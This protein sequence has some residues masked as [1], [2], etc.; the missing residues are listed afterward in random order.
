MFSYGFKHAL[1][2]RGLESSGGSTS[3]V[4]G[5]HFPFEYSAHLVRGVLCIGNI[6]ADAVHVALEYSPRKHIGRE[7]AVA[8]FRAAERHR[9][10]YAEGHSIHYPTRKSF[11]PPRVLGHLFEVPCWK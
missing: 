3:E 10:V 1:Q 8:A 6:A 11:H 4:N 9:N 2:L 7:I 5:I